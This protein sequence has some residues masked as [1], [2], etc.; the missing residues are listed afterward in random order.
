MTEIM[1]GINP[2]YFELPFSATEGMY[3]K[4][5]FKAVCFLFLLSFR[6]FF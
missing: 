4:D 5:G 6:L 1:L 3:S 2:L